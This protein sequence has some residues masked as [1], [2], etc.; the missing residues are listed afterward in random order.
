MITSK[1]NVFGLIYA[2]NQDTDPLTSLDTWWTCFRNGKMTHG[3]AKSRE[4]V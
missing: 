4:V 1:A 2:D 3:L